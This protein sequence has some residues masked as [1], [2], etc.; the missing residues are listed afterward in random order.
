M[1]LVNNVLLALGCI[2]VLVVAGIKIFETAEALIRKFKESRA[3]KSIQAS[4]QETTNE[5]EGMDNPTMVKALLTRLNCQY[6]ED[7]EGR[8]YF[9]YQAENFCICTTADS[10]WIHICDTSWFRIPLENLDEI[11]CMKK[12]VNQANEEAMGKVVYYIN[13]NEKVFEVYSIFDT[14]L[15]NQIPG[16]QFFLTACFSKL[17]NLKQRTISAFE[18][19]KQKIREIQQQPS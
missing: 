5:Y 15:W 6:Q 16:P 10:A 18:E 14:I 9:T 7:E 8:I 1:N 2:F 4:E 19:E 12:A 3:A 11:N 13:D 17:F